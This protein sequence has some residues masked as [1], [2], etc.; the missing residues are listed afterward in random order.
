[1]ISR[2]HNS[3]KDQFDFIANDKYLRALA[4]NNIEMA[5]KIYKEWNNSENLS[6]KCLEIG[7][8]GGITKILR[9]NWI[10]TD[11]RP[12]EGIDFL[13]SAEA[14][15]FPDESFDI[16]FAIDVIH[17]IPDKKLFFSEISRLLSKGEKADIQKV[18]D[19]DGGERE[20]GGS[21]LSE[22]LTGVYLH[23]LFGV[24]CILKFSR[25]RN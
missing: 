8:A 17:H 24:F 5:E 21:F 2:K 10:V 19:G 16:I 23:N 6:L 1:M 20:G 3:L 4:I 9:P 18:K 13:A 22:N 7:G 15:P 14:L 25:L 11:V 12:A